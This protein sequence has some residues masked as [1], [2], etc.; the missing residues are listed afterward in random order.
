VLQ[1]G[2]KPIQHPPDPLREEFPATPRVFEATIAC[3]NNLL[4]NS[5][6]RDRLRKMF[7]AKAVEMEG[8]GVADA[9]LQ[10]GQAG[11]I[12]VRGTC[13]YCNATKNDVWQNYAALIAAAFTR[14]LIEEMP[15]GR[16]APS[17]VQVRPEEMEIH[18]TSDLVREKA[19][20]L[21]ESIKNW[22][23]SREVEMALG[24]ASNLEAW[25][26]EH[27]HQVGDEVTFQGYTLLAK[28]HM[29][30]ADHAAQEDQKQACIRKARFFLEKAKD[31]I[32]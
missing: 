28:A 11:Y 3:A 10:C 15:S 17:A 16:G 18:S 20:A 26:G 1:D 13:D 25:L 7:S 6:R 24:V 21:C 31:V 22:L 2:D 14:A 12:I 32:R 30:K 5:E 4:K 29:A 27:R 19:E 8:S 23:A 9:V